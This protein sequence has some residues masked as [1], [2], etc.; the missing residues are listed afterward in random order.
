MAGEEREL[1]AFVRHAIQ[2]G[3]AAERIRAAV[4]TLGHS[5]A[6]ID[7]V[8]ELEPAVAPEML[9]AVEHIDGAASAL[10]R[11]ANFLATR[12]DLDAEGSLPTNPKEE[13]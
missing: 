4:E 1:A 12:F 11:A 10:E 8:R 5:V 7:S 13:P 2:Y 9:A 6:A 3:R